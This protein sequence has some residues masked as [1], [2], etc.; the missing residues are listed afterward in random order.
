MYHKNRVIILFFIFLCLPTLAFGAN[1]YVRDGGS[2]D[3]SSWTNAWDNLPSTLTR[4][5]TYY[6]ADGSYGSYDCD[7]SNSGSTYIYIKKCY[8]GEGTCDEITGWQSSY[9]D[10]QAVFTYLEL[11]TD[12]WDIEGCNGVAD[13][14]PST[15]TTTQGIA[16]RNLASHLVLFSGDRSYIALKHVEIDGTDNT[17]GDRD[18]VYA[19]SGMDHITISY[20][21]IYDV[22]CDIFQ[23]RGDVDN[24]TVEYTKISGTRS[25]DCHADVNEWDAS[26]ATAEN[27]VFRYNWID[28]CESA[29]CLGCGHA[30][31]NGT[32]DNFQ[33]YGNIFSGNSNST[34]IAGGLNSNDSG[35][36]SDMKF[37][38]NTMYANAG[39]AESSFVNLRGSGNVAY[40]NLYHS[41]DAGFSI[42]THDYNYFYDAGGT[43]AESNGQSGSS[44]IL[45]NPASDDFTL[46]GA[47]DA[48]T[49]LNSPYN[50][51]MTGAMRGADGIWDRGAYEYESGDTTPK[52]SG[53][54]VIKGTGELH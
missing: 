28:D 36:F 3:G 6:I 32:M 17:P 49:T 12:Y 48:G 4:G 13:D 34:G 22:A 42:A 40:N 1:H 43:Y 39:I 51:D 38:N 41:T 19:I 9:G 54:T 52:A 47:T 25:G 29:I 33:I 26:A 46:T 31:H 5:D 21:H 20:C 10:G 35:T 15:Y 23:T 50:Q 16:V 30:G 7:T 27:W 53:I 37:Y 24:F 14:L 11:S 44:G 45:A 2:G 18:A 8:D